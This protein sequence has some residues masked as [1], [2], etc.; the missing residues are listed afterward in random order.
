MERND[1]NGKYACIRRSVLAIYLNGLRAMRCTNI[2]SK[3]D[4]RISLCIQVHG[5]YMQIQDKNRSQY[6]GRDSRNLSNAVM[7]R[8]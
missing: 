4:A 7:T 6:D 3:C 8:K 2:N 5:K 1:Q